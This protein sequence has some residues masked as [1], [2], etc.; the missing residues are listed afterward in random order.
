[1]NSFSNPTLDDDESPRLF[2]I[3]RKRP[4]E[5]PALRHHHCSVACFGSSGYRGVAAI[6]G[7][8]W[9]KPLTGADEECPRDHADAIGREDE[10][11]G[12]QLVLWG[13]VL[14]SVSQVSKPIC[15]AK[16]TISWRVRRPSFSAIRARYVSTVFTLTSICFAM[17]L[18]P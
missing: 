17:S 8:A 7:S 3:D 13:G 12:G 6:I 14:S 15:I 1:M 2:L 9:V 16:R 4:R 5:R 10:A 11:A 18:L